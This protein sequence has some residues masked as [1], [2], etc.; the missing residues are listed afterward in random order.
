MFRLS[1]KEDLCDAKIA[2]IYNCSQATISNY[3]HK[4]GLGTKNIKNYYI[5]EGNIVKIQFR[6]KSNHYYTVV[7]TDIF[8]SQIK[9]YNVKWYGHNRRGN[10]Y[11]T[12]R[13]KYSDGYCHEFVRTPQFDLHRLVLGYPNV[14]KEG[15]EIDHINQ[16]TLDNRLLNLRVVSHAENMKNKKVYSNN[17]SGVVGVDFY[18]RNKYKKWMVSITVNGEK[19]HIGYFREKEKAIEARLNAEK[20]YFGDYHYKF[21]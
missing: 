2:K 16:N 10:I 6:Y 9:Q 19:I 8:K 7:D 18:D 4:W 3:R 15:Y 5:V 17:S 11:V 21:Q 12:A 20:E 13:N 1:V 14:D